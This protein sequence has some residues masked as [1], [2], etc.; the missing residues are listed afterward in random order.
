MIFSVI[1]CTYNRHALLRT[2]MES[3]LAQDF[4]ENNYEIIVVDN[5]SNHDTLRTAE[6]IQRLHPTRNIAYVREERQ[7]LS[8]ARNSGASAARGRILAY[9]D[10]DAE[11]HPQ[12]LRELLRAFESDPSISCVGGRV[13]AK[14]DR[15]E[16]HWFVGTVRGVLE[17]DLGDSDREITP[18]S[19]FIGCNFAILRKTLE[20]IGG[21]NTNLG[22]I[23]NCLL[24][25]EELDLLHRMHERGFKTMYSATQG[26]I[27]RLPPM[28]SQ[29]STHGRDSTGKAYPIC[30]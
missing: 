19:Y 17:H 16:P 9:M 20:E 14:W 1:V 5:G 11:A 26:S 8:F 27:I 18:P 15:K 30:V 13:L 4:P 10:D 24:S 29:D 28:N 3:A 25:N 23:G 2:A 21:F 6:Q 12:W 7:G 22:H